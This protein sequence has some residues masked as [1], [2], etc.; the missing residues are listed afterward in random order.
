MRGQ[1]WLA[2]ALLVA[3]APAFA[4][5]TTTNKTPAGETYLQSSDG[6]ALYVFDNDKATGTPAPSTCYDQCEKLWPPF[7]AGAEAQPHGDWS[8]ETR[9]DGT[10]Q[11]AY[12]SRPVYFF[13]RDK[14][15]GKT[16][17]NGF[18]GNRWHLVEP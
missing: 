17:G 16:E 15:P 5:A 10:K 12:K 3:S 9:K 11:W 13:A 4:Q 1:I 2:A 7:T 6:K 14:V 18:N 8:V